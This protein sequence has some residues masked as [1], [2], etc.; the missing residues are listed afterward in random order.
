[1]D[2]ATRRRLH[3]ELG[4]DADLEFVYKFSYRVK[5]GELGSENELCSVYLGRADQMYSANASEIAEA[6]FLSV[7]A[8][9]SALQTNPDKFT[10]WFKMEWERLSSEF[11]ETLIKYAKSNYPT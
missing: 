9:Q 2:M 6:K 10:P 3:E 5:F 1:M 4:V 8:L 11:A 7:E